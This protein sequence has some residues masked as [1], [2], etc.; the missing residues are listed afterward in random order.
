MGCTPVPL[1]PHGN[2]FLGPKFPGPPA[3]RR[4]I[5]KVIHSSVQK[6]PPRRQK[7][8]ARESKRPRPEPGGMNQGS[9]A[10]HAFPCGTVVRRKNLRMACKPD[11]VR[12]FPPVM[13]IH[14]G[15]PSRTGSSSQPGPAGGEGA[16]GALP[17]HAVP[18]WPCS[19]R[20]LPCR[21]RYRPRGGL[22]PHRFTLTPGV[23]GAVCFLWRFPSAFAG[24]FL[25]GVRTFL[26]PEGPRP[27]GHP[28]GLACKRR[29]AAGQAPPS[30]P[31]PG[32]RAAISSATATSSRS[33]DAPPA[34]GRNR[35]RKAAST[36]SGAPR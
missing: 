28:Q 29:P 18:I 27:S 26:G 35:S 15:R 32:K 13:A 19:R 24:R 11:S 21:D 6:I 4:G 8:R 36:S 3:E 2:P 9:G 30:Q 14:L 10:G 5:P 23:P 20:G 31:G 1:N 16:P 34:Q 12:A 7:N 33:S 25:R 17:P 22:L